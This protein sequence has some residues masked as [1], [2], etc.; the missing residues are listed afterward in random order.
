MKGYYNRPEE[1]AQ[2]I[3]AEGWFRTGDIGEVDAQGFLKITDRKKDLLKTSG[4]K[5]VAPAVVENRLK[6]CVFVEQSVIVGDGRKFVALLVVPAFKSLEEWAREQRIS[7]TGRAELIENAVVLRHMESVVRKYF[8]GLAAYETPK[9]IALLEEEFTVQNGF[10]T[11]S[12]KVKRRV[13]QDRFKDLID[14][15]YQGAGGPSD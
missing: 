10:L 4:G 14:G 12:L 5:Y 7:W 3:D 8:E 9:K 1:T 15:L 2:T 11:P 6:E 13:V